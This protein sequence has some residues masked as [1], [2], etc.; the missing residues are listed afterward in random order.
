LPNLAARVHDQSQGIPLGIA[1]DCLLRNQ[2]GLV[3]DAFF[4]HRPDEHA[5]QKNPVCIR[6]D[7]A[8]NYSRRG[9]IYRYV[10]ELKRPFR[11]ILRAVSQE[12]LDLVCVRPVEA[13]E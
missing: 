10:A 13:D 3:V 9:R 5:R 11:R 1:R 12:E 2:D 8:Q 6:E 4:H 7:H